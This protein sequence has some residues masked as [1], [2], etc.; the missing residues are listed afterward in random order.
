MFVLLRGSSYYATLSTILLLSEAV[1]HFL[2]LLIEQVKEERAQNIAEKG[3]EE[4]KEE[5]TKRQSQRAIYKKKMTAKT[6]HGQPVMRHQ[7][8]YL[9]HKIKHSK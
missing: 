4:K 3:D 7:I 5:M 9:L 1:L 6:K 8:G 2:Y